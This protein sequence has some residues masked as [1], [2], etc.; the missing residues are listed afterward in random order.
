MKI[1]ENLA[2]PCVSQ[3]CVSLKKWCTF[4]VGRQSVYYWPNSTVYFNILSTTT[5]APIRGVA[6]L[7]V[8]ARCMNCIWES[9]QYSTYKTVELWSILST[10][11]YLQYLGFTSHDNFELLI[12]SIQDFETRIHIFWRVLKSRKDQ[13]SIH[14]SWG[15]IN[16]S[17]LCCNG[18]WVGG[19]DEGFGRIFDT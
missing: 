13:I 5:K 18:S 9:K 10:T 11:T 17:L 3:C 19:G 16:C 1:R 14:T 12:I 2:L 7:H 8:R 4:E 15:K 6:A